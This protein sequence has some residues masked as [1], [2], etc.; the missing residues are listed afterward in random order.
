M[1]PMQS[2]GAAK[3]SDENPI[4]LFLVDDQGLFRASLACLLSSE[5]GFEVAGECGSAV[6]IDILK[7]AP[8]D[9]VL[10]D[11]DLGGERVADFICA[12]RMAGY[13]GRFLI[14]A[15]ASDAVTAAPAL[16]LG[17]SGIF[18]ASESPD[19]V[20][21][22]IRLVAAGAVWVDQLVIQTLAEKYVPATCA[23][24]LEERERKVLTGI[25][26][27][28]TNRKIGLDIGL[29][30][31]SVKAIVQRLFAKAGVRTR[32]QLVRRALDGSFL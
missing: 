13:S 17:A 1:R 8:A 16:K 4:R 22:A 15:R 18:L 11:L 28:L 7:N 31:G 23:I 12:A 20:V 14:L 30:E 10:L 29:S 25:V 21:Q 27:G 9:V 2:A 24:R 26:S 6:A 3:S 32:G 19:R 5:P